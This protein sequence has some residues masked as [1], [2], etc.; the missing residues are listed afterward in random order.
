MRSLFESKRIYLI[1]LGWKK[2]IGQYVKTNGKPK[3]TL[4]LI[5][6]PIVDPNPI[7][8][9]HSEVKCQVDTTHVNTDD[10]LFLLIQELYPSSRNDY[11]I[12]NCNEKMAISILLNGMVPDHDRA[13]EHAFNKAIN[14]IK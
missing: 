13:Y 3:G 6:M 14:R 1:I 9:I 10:K 7:Q 2:V 12:V 4:H 11:D 8:S 5:Q